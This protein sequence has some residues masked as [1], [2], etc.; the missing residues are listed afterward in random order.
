MKKLIKWGLVAIVIVLLLLGGGAFY[1][2]GKIDTLAKAA[3]E[4]GA[5]YALGVN[6]S[7]GK[8]RVGIFS[9]AFGIDDLAIANPQG[10][11]T[12]TF[13]GLK[14]GDVK[15]SLASLSKDVVEVPKIGL[16]GVRVSL[17][18]ADGRTNYQTI[19]DN[20]KR[21]EG[22]GGAKPAPPKDAGA[23]KKFIV[24][25]VDIRD[26]NVHLDLAGFGG[27]LTQLDVP[28]SQVRLTNIG[29][30]DGAGVDIPTLAS[31]V[32][33]AVLAAVVAKGQGIIPADIL[34][35][36]QGQLAKLDALG[37]VGVEVVG[38]AGEKVEAIGRQAREAIDEQAKAVQGKVDE[39][40][41]K[42]EDAV[43]K[44]TE[45]VGKA[46]DKNLGDAAKKAED[47]LKGLLPGK[48]EA[49]KPAEPKPE[50]PKP[51]EPKKDGGA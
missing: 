16:S 19:L 31:T 24:R 46:I 28:I 7:L 43:G 42:V 32:L 20:L 23:E 4:K 11:K 6:T 30:A 40:V 35:D 36:L 34:N 29:T 2:I 5:T 12:P 18:R 45:D 41:K 9:G 22:E 21:L 1:A 15:V 48:K 10:F 50:E 25:E 14:G 37:K 49:P 51:A 13:F 39:T 33:Q 44:A 47:R 3:I 8:A 17:E 26:I 27:E 38:K